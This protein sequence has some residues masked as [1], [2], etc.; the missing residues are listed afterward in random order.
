MQHAAAKAPAGAPLP[1]I[2]AA[3]VAAVSKAAED[4]KL[5]TT[6]DILLK[7]KQQAEAINMGAAQLGAAMQGAKQKATGGSQ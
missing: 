1:D 7:S 5:L 3:G 6:E 2:G 4:I